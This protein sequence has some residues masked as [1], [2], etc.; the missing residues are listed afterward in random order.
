M[1]AFASCMRSHGV[2]SFPD[3]N[4]QG[5]IPL[6]TMNR[7]DPSSPAV[8]SAFKTCEPLESKVGPRIEFGADGSV[9]E[10]R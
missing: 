3:P 7:I 4:S 1:L 10:R 9:A 6:A 5:L 2:P 8:L